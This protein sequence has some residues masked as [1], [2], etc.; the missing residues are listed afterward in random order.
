MREEKKEEKRFTSSLGEG[1]T[2]SR[3][4][5]QHAAY[6]SYA[7]A[8]NTTTGKAPPC[9]LFEVLGRITY[10]AVPLDTVRDSLHGASA[11]TA[12]RA[13][14]VTRRILHRMYH[15]CGNTDTY[16]SSLSPRSAALLFTSCLGVSARSN[17]PTR[18]RPYRCS[19]LLRFLPLHLIIVHNLSLLP[20]RESHF[21]PFDD[22][23]FA[24]NL[25]LLSSTTSSKFIRFHLAE[26]SLRS[27]LLHKTYK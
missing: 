11:Y 17:P 25:S 18:P 15:Q 12:R 14:V 16:F 23:L 3:I 19:I 22:H 13:R 24:R 4:D 1:G 2:V 6:T 9:K 27:I 8:N 20:L 10:R 21:S 26:F 7:G 5:M